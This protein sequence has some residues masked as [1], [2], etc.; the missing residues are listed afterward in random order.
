MMPKHDG[1]DKHDGADEHTSQHLPLPKLS[2]PVTNDDIWYKMHFDIYLDNNE[3][4]KKSNKYIDLEAKY[5]SKLCEFTKPFLEMIKIEDLLPKKG[6]IIVEYYYNK[7]ISGYTSLLGYGNILDKEK[8]LSQLKKENKLEQPEIDK[9]E[10]KSKNLNQ[11][12]N[13]SNKN[14]DGSSSNKAVFNHKIKPASAININMVI[15]Q[16]KKED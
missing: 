7:G 9:E 12:D 5:T 16:T 13:D 4:V 2:I 10:I 14:D 1:T 6:N 3:L 8:I 11:E 15:K